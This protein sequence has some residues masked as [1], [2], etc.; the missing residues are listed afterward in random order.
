R[1]MQFQD[2]DSYENSEH[3]VGERTQS[4]RGLFRV[5]HGRHP[6]DSRSC[7]TSESSAPPPVRPTSPR[8]HPSEAPYRSSSAPRTTAP[9][10]RASRSAVAF[11]I[12][13][14]APVTMATGPDMLFSLR[15]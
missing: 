11:P 6:F 14:L 3:S 7:R 15:L 8:R 1:G 5:W 13:E 10:S 12:P 4:L 2:E 9:K